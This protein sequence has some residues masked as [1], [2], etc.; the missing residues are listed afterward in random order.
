MHEQVQAD[1][2]P[3]CIY[4]E[5][6]GYFGLPTPEQLA[7]YHIVVCTCGAAG[8]PFAPLFFCIGL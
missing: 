3:K 1:V 7:A 8:G 5:E 6:T 2:R 4:N